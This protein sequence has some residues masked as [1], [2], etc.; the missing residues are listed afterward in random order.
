MELLEAQIKKIQSLCSSGKFVEAMEL[1]RE[2][3]LKNPSSQSA[4]RC[5]ANVHNAMNDIPLALADCDEAIKLGEAEPHDLCLRA[6]LHYDLGNYQASE[7]DC[8]RALEI[9]EA[10][11]FHY[12]DEYCHFFRSVARIGLRQYEMAFEDADFVKDNFVIFTRRD[13]KVTKQDLMKRIVGKSK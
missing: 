5:R 8:T 9:G 7:S 10:T 11:K 12:Y 13:G 4:F 6:Q 3:V 1:A 2:L